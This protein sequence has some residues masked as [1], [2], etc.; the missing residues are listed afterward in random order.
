MDLDNYNYKWFKIDDNHEIYFDFD[1]KTWR[2]LEDFFIVVLR[3]RDSEDVHD[4]PDNN[5]YAVDKEANIL[6]NIKDI[7][8]DTPYCGAIYFQ[9]SNEEKTYLVAVDC[10]G[11]HHTIDL[12]NRTLVESKHWRFAKHQGKSCFGFSDTLKVKD[13]YLV[14]EQNLCSHNTEKQPLNNIY[15]IDQNVN[16]LWNISEIVHEENPYDG[17]HLL[18]STMDIT[19]LDAISFGVHYTI[20]L[21]SKQLISKIGYR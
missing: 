9:P 18:L 7:L 8:G 1:V 11:Y 4:Q 13:Y 19:Y 3:N 2:E 6:W 15:T 12:K 10:L 14:C 17:F 5:I 16:I 20:D 21:T